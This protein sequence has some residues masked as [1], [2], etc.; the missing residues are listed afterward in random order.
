MFCEIVI[1][2][3]ALDIETK[4]WDENSGYG[5]ESKEDCNILADAFEPII[6]SLEEC[7]DNLSMDEKREKHVNDLRFYTNMMV[8]Q[9]D[10]SNPFG[11]CYEDGKF[12]SATDWTP[13][14]AE[15]YKKFLNGRSISHSLEATDFVINGKKIRSSYSVA[16]DHLKEFMHFLRHCGGFEIW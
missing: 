1:Q 12:I 6:E 2:H 5:L 10:F 14:V 15:S 7:F 3:G 9:N 4:G 11:I 8:I 16:Y 13:Q